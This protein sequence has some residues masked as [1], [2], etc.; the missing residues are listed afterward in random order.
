MITYEFLDWQLITQRMTDDIN[1]LLP[2]L[3][4]T[5]KPLT[6]KHVGSIAFRSHLLVARTEDGA[7]KGMA[8]LCIIQTPTG[9]KGIIEDVVVDA[10]L[11]GHGAGTTLMIG[12]I[13]E[14]ARHGTKKLELT[15]NPARAAANHLYQ[16]LG[17]KLRETNHYRMTL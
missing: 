11:C 17:F 8:T 16:K 13:G 14:A 7:I 6:T 10:S 4:A 3:T 1:L 12:L 9:Q 5:A 2:Q 15:S